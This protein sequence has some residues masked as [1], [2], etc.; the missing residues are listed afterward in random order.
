MLTRRQL[1]VRG[2]GLTV[3]LAYFG[4]LPGG[5]AADPPAL[6][7][8]HAGAYAALLDLIDADPA[9][10]LPDRVYRVPRFA[11]LYGDADDAF[12]AWADAALDDFTEHGRA[13]AAA[14][15]LASLVYREPDSNTILFTLS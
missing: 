8:E 5:A 2:G 3:A 9:Y 13:G 14:L 1:L 6:S 4:T 7:A 10:E 11:E 12:R 15:D